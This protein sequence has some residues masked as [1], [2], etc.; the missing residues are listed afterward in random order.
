MRVP[1][2]LVAVA[3]LAGAAFAFSAPADAECVGSQTYALVCATV[4][5]PAVDP[6]GNTFVDCIHVV[7]PPCIE[8]KFNYPSVGPISPDPVDVTCSGMLMPRC[9]D[10][11]LG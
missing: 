7:V 2:R 6:T 11:T 4:D 3:A 10:F 5:L 1:A 9:P 8:V